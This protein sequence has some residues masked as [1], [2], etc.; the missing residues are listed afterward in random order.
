MYTHACTAVATPET[1]WSS[2]PNAGASYAFAVFFGLAFMAHV[3]QGVYYK[4]AY[5]WVIAMS[6]TR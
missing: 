1:L 3:A 2:C 6:G 4:K 5:T